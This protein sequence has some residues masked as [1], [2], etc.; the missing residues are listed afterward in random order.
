MYKSVPRAV[1]LGL[2]S[3]GKEEETPHACLCRKHG[4]QDGPLSVRGTEG[5]TLVSVLV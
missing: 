5:P 1:A 2:R 3:E 4:R